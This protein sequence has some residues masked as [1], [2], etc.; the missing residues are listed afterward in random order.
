[1]EIKQAILTPI[2]AIKAR[3]IPLLLI[4]F[5]YGASGFTAIVESFWVKNS[6]NLSAEALVA[7]GVWLTVPWTIKMIFGQMVDSIAIFGSKRKVYVVIGALLL[8]FGILLMIGLIQENHLLSGFKKGNIYIFAS[9]VMVIGYV[10]QDVVADTMSTEVVDR[11]QSQEDIE[12][13]LAMI[14]VLGRLSLGIAIF[15]V[16]G[17][18]G[19]LTDIYSYSTIYTISLLIPVISILGIIFIKLNPV[20]STPLNLPIFIGGFLFAIFIV[21]MGYNDVPYSQEI[22]FAISLIVVLSMLKVLIND[23]DKATKR[24]IV[25]AMIIIFV[26]RATPNVGPALQWW[27]IDVLKFDEPFFG[28]LSQI[29][30]AIALIG[31]WVSSSFI[32]KQKIGK[33]LIFLTVIG[34]FLSLPVVGM[35]YGLHTQLGLDAHTVALVDTA[36]SSPF[37]YISNVLMLTLVAIYAPEGKRGTWFALMASLMNIALSASGLFTKYLNNIFVVTREVKENGV[38][39][40]VANYD[41]LGILLWIVIVASTVIPLI[42]IW[43]FDPQKDKN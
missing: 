39:T 12:H 9:V 22:V 38:L 20:E 19:W 23:L 7:L 21:L 33:V 31:M 32:V 42:A 18:G 14:Q 41:N 8:T 4:Y 34:F 30:A 10:I 13:E 2:L 35:Y 11:N 1:M 27:E 26:Y 5:A 3:Y 43:K 40:S 16:S 25:M 29:G 28:T 15:M 17:L 6:L 36:V 24:H 37:D